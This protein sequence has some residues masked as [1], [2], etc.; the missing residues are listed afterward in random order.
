MFL[1]FHKTRN[2]PGII[3]YLAVSGTS[4]N[5]IK[6]AKTVEKLIKANILSKYFIS[7]EQWTNAGLKIRQAENRNFSNFIFYF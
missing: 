4:S 3:G 2:V 1:N 5:H 6:T 7:T